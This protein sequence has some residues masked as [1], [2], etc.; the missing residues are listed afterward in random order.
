MYSTHNEGKLIVTERFIRTLKGKIYKNITANDSKFY[1]SYLNK[2]VVEY[3]N[4]YHHFISKKP[5]D[6]N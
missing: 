6:A 3:N 1:F 2:I 5:I 4:T